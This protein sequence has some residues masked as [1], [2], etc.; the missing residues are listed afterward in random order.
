MSKPGKRPLYP[1]LV[2][3]LHWLPACEIFVSSL[4]SLLLL[5]FVPHSLLSTKFPRLIFFG[6]AEMLRTQ[7]LLAWSWWSAVLAAAQEVV[8]ITD[9]AIFTD[10]PPCAA[11]AVSLNVQSQTDE[12]CPEAVTDLQS[13]VCTKNNNFASIST[14]ISSSVSFSCGSTAS[15]DQTSAASVFSV[16][17]NKASATTFPSP[18]FPVTQYITDLPGWG[19]LAY[20]A[21]S[22]LSA[23]VQGMTWDLCP[24]EPTLLAPCV[25]TKNQ[26]SLLVSQ[27]INSSVKYACSSHT[28]DI[29]SAQALFSGYCGLGNGTSSF[30]ETTDPPGDM[31]YYISAMPEYNSLA[32]C[33]QTAVSY[34]VLYQTA[35]LCPAG[36][37]ALASCACLRDDMSKVITS[38]ITSDVKVY[39]DDLASEDVTSALSVY[40]MYC[41][42]AKGLV[43]PSGVTQSIGETS[44]TGNSGSS[45]A[46]ETGSSSSSSNDEVSG[47]SSTQASGSGSTQASNVRTIVGAV[48]GV[49]VGLILIALAA[50]FFWRRS[51]RAKSQ[52]QANMAA[53]SS[54]FDKP[55]LD[56]TAVGQAPGT[57]PSM[58]TVQAHGVP[59][60]DNVSPVS[61]H[62]SPYTEL[63]G[64]NSY[65]PP[66]AIASEL[67][68][69]NIYARTSELQTPGVNSPQTPH[70]AHG[71][72]VSE[73]HGMGWQAGP[74]AQYHEMDGANTMHQHPQ[75]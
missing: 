69:Q 26:N 17:C 71:Q 59:R 42:A 31:T 1:I 18:S 50:F 39:C 66:P 55:E 25:C 4:V 30:P 70:E 64:H 24:E 2:G 52:N 37:Q 23:V 33:A 35:D 28:M 34:G 65:P 16:Y 47:S 38:I 44:A 63:Q 41:S 73:L 21:R 48:V 53:G 22:G 43:T 60:S 58:S 62:S 27:K 67:H 12:N 29:A 51:Q 14:A 5:T 32:R 20:C 40:E 13:C 57:S 7:S 19:E 61:G 72:P 9:L 8:Y 56:N 54:G 49:V 11:T 10:L 3:S 75:R 6:V 15:D 68:N 74:V 45:I 36:P 46:T